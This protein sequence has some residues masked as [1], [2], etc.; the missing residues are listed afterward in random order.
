SIGVLSPW[1]VVANSSP[2]LQQGGSS[3]PCFS[4]LS[5]PPQTPAIAFYSSYILRQK[6]KNL[7]KMLLESGNP[8]IV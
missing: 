5:R 8:V 3:T 1:L 6:A 2:P 4:L 7:L